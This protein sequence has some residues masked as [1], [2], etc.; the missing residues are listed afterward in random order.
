MPCQQDWYERIS[1]VWIDAVVVFSVFHDKYFYH[2]CTSNYCDGVRINRR[3]KHWM[4]AQICISLTLIILLFFF[5]FKITLNFFNRHL[6]LNN[7]IH[8]PHPRNCPK[9]NAVIRKNIHVCT[10]SSQYWLSPWVKISHVSPFAVN[11]W[12]PLNHKNNLEII[13]CFF[14]WWICKSKCLSWRVSPPP[15]RLAWSTV[16]PFQP[17]EASTVTS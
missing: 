8:F 3:Y 5:T 2:E 17:Q 4:I 12:K 1:K 7:S 16:M 15:V 11:I 14:V 9:D 6:F 10:S 13:C